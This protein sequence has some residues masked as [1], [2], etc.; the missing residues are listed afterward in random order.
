MSQELI[1]L[2]DIVPNPFRNM[3]RYPIDEAKV[4]S[5]VESFDRTGYWGNIVGRRANGK[6]EFAYG[7]HRRIAMQRKKMKEVEVIIRE[8]SDADML[9]MMADENMTEWA[10]NSAV[11]QETIR[12]VVLAYSDGK[13]E[14]ERPAD[15]VPLSS[16]R[17]A[18]EFSTVKKDVFKNLK[19]IPKPYNAESI[20]RFL[21][22]MSG[23]QV[24]P[25]V[26]NALTVLETAEAMEAPE[27]FKEMTEGLSSDKAKDVVKHVESIRRSHEKAGASPKAAITKAIKAGKAIAQDMREGKATIRE[28][29][30]TALKYRPQKESKIPD[31]AA[32]TERL[33]GD[34][35]DVL[36]YGKLKD[37]LDKLVEWREYLTDPEQKKLIRILEELAG[38]CQSVI[39]KLQAAVTEGQEDTVLIPLTQHYFTHYRD[40][41]PDTEK[42]ARRCVAGAM[43]R[44]GRAVGFCVPGKDILT[45]V[46]RKFADGAAIGHV[47]NAKAKDEKLIDRLGLEKPKVHLQNRL[48]HLLK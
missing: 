17:N 41:L 35:N 44:H 24:S 8:V 13:I 19:D 26:R 2:K 11:E 46:W 43:P 48:Q 18:P 7:H 1:S 23:E 30:E 25:R 47:N 39:K 42:E 37:N 15:K 38:R 21:G 20:A 5:L 22:W 33:I 28:A 27:E 9:R 36:R 10:T 31:M 45:H 3:E 32:F 12:S 6:V 14:L 16:I 29:R 4:K 34:I 40:S